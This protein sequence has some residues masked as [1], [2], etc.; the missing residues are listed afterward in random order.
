MGDLDYILSDP[1]S[2]FDHI[3]KKLYQSANQ[4]TRDLITTGRQEIEKTPG[5]RNKYR[6]VVRYM[7]MVEELEGKRLKG[8]HAVLG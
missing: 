7:A 3:H 5:K 8:V 4:E 6:L 1:L 2:F